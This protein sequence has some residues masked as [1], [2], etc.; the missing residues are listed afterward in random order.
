MGEG[1]VLAEE[2]PA[3]DGSYMMINPKSFFND[4]EKTKIVTAIQQAEAKTSG[5]IRVHI[6]KTRAADSL[7]HAKD[8]FEKIGMTKTRLRNGVLIYINPANKSVTIIGDGGIDEKVED[9]FWDGLAY[10]TA[11]KFRGGKY[12]DGVLDAIKTIGDELKTKFPRRS[13]DVNELKD[14][15]SCR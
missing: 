6:D 7:R 10:S 11:G 2:E 14:D 3:G 9:G 1:A 12:I 8:I 4:D 13:D 5:E 15:I